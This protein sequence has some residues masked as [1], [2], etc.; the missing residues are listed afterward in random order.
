MAFCGLALLAVLAGSL[1]AGE[2]AG[3]LSCDK[4]TLTSFILFHHSRRAEI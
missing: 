1:N 4:K 2:D 3:L